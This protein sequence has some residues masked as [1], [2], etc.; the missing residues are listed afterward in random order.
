MMISDLYETD[1]AQWTQAQIEA[2]K[3]KD[4]ERIDFEHLIENL[5]MGDPKE[6]IESNLVILIAHLLKLAIQ[7]DAPDWMNNSWYNSIDEHRKR[8]IKAKRKYKPITKYLPT[9]VEN[10]YSDARDLAIKE[11]KRA[12]GRKVIRRDE[13]EYPTR[14]PF[15]L[16]QILDEDWYPEL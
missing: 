9:A 2:L 12:D 14:C 10:A 16:E 15:T 13:S 4:W 1:Y 3:A 6:T 11:G 7:Q 5:E 8:I